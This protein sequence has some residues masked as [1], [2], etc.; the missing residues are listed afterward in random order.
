MFDTTNIILSYPEV[1]RRLVALATGNYAK[2]DSYYKHFH[3]YFKAHPFEIEYFLKHNS[4]WFFSRE[5]AEQEVALV[6]HKTITKYFSPAGKKQ[7]KK[8]YTLGYLLHQRG[9]LRL[10][11]LLQKRFRQLAV[12]S[13][14]A[15]V[16]EWLTEPSVERPL[17]SAAKPSALLKRGSLSMK[18][19]MFLYR[20]VWEGKTTGELEKEFGGDWAAVQKLI[21]SLV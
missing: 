1:R 2:I 14:Y 18:Q 9:V 12:D 21:E 13:D 3:S 6:F 10:T 16:F 11:R 8:R 5:D 15:E 17:L 20:I 4:G 19:K 7:R